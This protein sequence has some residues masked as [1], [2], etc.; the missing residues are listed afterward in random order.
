MKTGLVS[1]S[2]RH[3]SVDDIID[4]CQQAKLD[5][6]EWGGDIHAPHGDAKTA[7]IVQHKTLNAGLKVAG[8]GSYY[9]VA[10]EDDDNPDF[11]AV[12]KSAV[13]LGA[14]SIRVW[15]G[16]RPSK[17]VDDAYFEKLVQDSLRIADLSRK[18]NIKIVYEYHFGTMTDHVDSARRLLQAAEH[19]H[20]ETLWQ[21]TNFSPSS[22]SLENLEM[23]LP[24][25]NNVHVF[26]WIQGLGQVNIRRPLSEG[27][28]DW[29]KYLNK[30][31]TAENRFFLL[32]FFKD[33]QTSQ[34]FEDAQTLNRWIKNAS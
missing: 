26:H 4:L 10:G 33:N 19:S 2:F 12:L 30:M 21:T 9:R 32:E 5:G 16:S 8:Y 3:L 17:E 7:E 14:P 11:E 18:E 23:V 13:A 6:I 22:V 1:V 29:K 28:V 27:E 25:L 24:K 34:F 20:I 15:A 31:G